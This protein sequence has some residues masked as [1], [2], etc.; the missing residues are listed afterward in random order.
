MLVVL[1]EELFVCQD[2]CVGHDDK[3][4]SSVAG[5]HKRVRNQARI[6]AHRAYLSACPAGE[7][8]F[9]TTLQA[10]HVFSGLVAQFRPVQTGDTA[11][12]RASQPAS[13]PTSQLW[14]P[15]WLQTAVF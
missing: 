3:I 9:R 11:A 14:V 7:N 4:A 6:S 13:E 15:D 8:S 2:K 12:S 10:G 1:L 5:S